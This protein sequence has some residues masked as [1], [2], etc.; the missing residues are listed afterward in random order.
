MSHNKTFQELYDQHASA[1]KLF[2]DKDFL[3]KASNK[4]I[5]YRRPK[6]ICDSPQFVDERFSLYDFE[7]LLNCD[8]NWFLLVLATIARNSKLFDHIVPKDKGCEFKDGYI[9]INRFR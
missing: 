1:G 5:R 3:P 9:G 2:K 8:S 4:Q 7:Q 6:E